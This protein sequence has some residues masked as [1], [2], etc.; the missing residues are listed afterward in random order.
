[1]NKSELPESKFSVPDAKKFTCRKRNA[2]MLMA[3]TLDAHLQI[4]FSW[5]HFFTI[6]GLPRFSPKTNGINFYSKSLWFQS[7]WKERIKISIKK[8]S[9][10]NYS[11]HSIRTKK[12]QEQKLV[13]K[14]GKKRTKRSKEILLISIKYCFYQFVILLKSHHFSTQKDKFNKYF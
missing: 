5:Y 10:V 11:L 3:L 1:V 12:N 14:I 7:I 13:Q 2:M 4:S 6:L 9:Q 8:R